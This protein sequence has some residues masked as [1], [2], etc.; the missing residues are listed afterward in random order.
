MKKCTDICSQ[1]WINIV[2]CGLFQCKA[3]D[4]AHLLRILMS[5]LKGNLRL[6]WLALH[7]NFT[8]VSLPIVK[9]PS[10]FL[11]S[12]G[13]SSEP[14]TTAKGVETM[15]GKRKKNLTGIYKGFKFAAC[16]SG[17]VHI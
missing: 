13:T 16:L 5:E 15:E 11:Y 17:S 6:I 4:G 3:L 7:K 9:K 2:Q 10:N 14:E 1:S 8:P 12:T